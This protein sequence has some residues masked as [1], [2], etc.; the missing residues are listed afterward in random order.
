MAELADIKSVMEERN[1]VDGI[2]SA[3][4]SHTDNVTAST[5]MDINTTTG[6][7]QPDPEAIG[8]STSSSMDS[9]SQ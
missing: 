6:N 4:V 5:K 2:V 9:V 7:Q 8:H 1:I 3:N